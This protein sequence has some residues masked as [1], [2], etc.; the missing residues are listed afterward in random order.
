MPDDPKIHNIIGIAGAA[1]SGKDTLCRSLMRVL[2]N[3]YNL[4]ESY[5]KTSI[6]KI[7]IFM[8]I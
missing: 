8:K 1:R 2:K 3:T 7:C 4:N 5:I 6:S